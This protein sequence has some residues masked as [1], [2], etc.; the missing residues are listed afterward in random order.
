[1]EVGQGCFSGQFPFFLFLCIS[2]H[3]LL[4]YRRL[5]IEI[6]E[7]VLVKI[8]RNKKHIEVRESIFWILDNHQE[9][10]EHPQGRHSPHTQDEGRE[11]QAVILL[12]MKFGV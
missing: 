2:F 12:T 7:Y 8:H 6:V 1:M 11:L 5:E 9:H 3:Y 10:Q 4:C